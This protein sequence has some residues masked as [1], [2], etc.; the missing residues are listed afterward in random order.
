ML[1]RKHPYLFFVESSRRQTRKQFNISCHLLLSP[2]AAAPVRVFPNSNVY[3][4][5]VCV[6]CCCVAAFVPR[7]SAG[8]INCETFGADQLTPFSATSG[9]QFPRRAHAPP[10]GRRPQNIFTRSAV[11]ERKPI[12][13]LQS[14]PSHRSPT[15]VRRLLVAAFNIA[16]LSI[17]PALAQ[18][19]CTNVHIRFYSVPYGARLCAAEKKPQLT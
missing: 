9:T 18:H 10:N 13:A 11:R 14:P 16:Q 1:L 2:V 15:Y 4:S 7:P 3:F 19:T 5:I 6:R 8:R 17:S 12:Y